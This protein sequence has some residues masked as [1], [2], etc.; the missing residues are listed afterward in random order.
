LNIDHFC[1]GTTGSFFN[2]QRYKLPVNLHGFRVRAGL[3]ER[4]LLP[5][6]AECGLHMRFHLLDVGTW[7]SHPGLAGS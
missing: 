5:Q 2:K 4:F 3:S 6:V 7:G 1:L